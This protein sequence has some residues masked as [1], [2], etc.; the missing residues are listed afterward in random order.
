MSENKIEIVD[1]KGEAKKME[2]IASIKLDSNGKDYVVYTENKET[3]LGNVQVFVSEIKE[4][5]Y[6]IDLIDIEDEN[7]W[8]E[9]QNKI[10]QMLKGV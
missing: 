7:V 2:V 4:N 9:I 1:E 5:E 6:D 10:S 8:R 3:K